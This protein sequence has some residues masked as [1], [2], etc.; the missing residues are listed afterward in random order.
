MHV[1]NDEA[2][3]EDIF[4]FF[5]FLAAIDSLFFFSTSADTRP[6]N[7]KIIFS[8]ESSSTPAAKINNLFQWISSRIILEQ[9]YFLLAL[10]SI[11]AHKG[12]GVVEF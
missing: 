9:T 3:Y 6:E 4:A 5:L 2:D 8:S 1:K 12:E 11:R 7:E 10:T